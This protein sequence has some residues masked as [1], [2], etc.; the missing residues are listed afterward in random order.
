MEEARS[1][2]NEIRA[3]AANAAGFV[4]EVIQGGTRTEYSTIANPA[5]NYNVEQYTAAW[6]NASAA[7]AAVRIETRIEFAM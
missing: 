7:R 5:A 2:V 4:P 1:Q 3:R 6:T